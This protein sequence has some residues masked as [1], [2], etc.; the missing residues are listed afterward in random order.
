MGNIFLNEYNVN[1]YVYIVVIGYDI[2]IDENFFFSLV[3]EIVGD[4]ISEL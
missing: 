2:G 1:V 3:V 4:R